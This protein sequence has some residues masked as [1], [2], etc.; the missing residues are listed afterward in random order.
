M[1]A[2]EAAERAHEE[3]VQLRKE[4][5]Q[6]VDRMV[7]ELAEFKRKLAAATAAVDAATTD[8]EREAA[9]AMVEAARQQEL[10]LDRRIQALRDL[11]AKALRSN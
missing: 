7:R 4:A 2:S 5:Q 3:F 9:K 10:E 11:A 1:T 8:A 6:S